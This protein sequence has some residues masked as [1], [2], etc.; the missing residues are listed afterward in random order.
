MTGA[1]LVNLVLLPL[2]LGLL[3]FIEPCS[4]GSSLLFIRY[5]GGK[6]ASAKL[7]QVIVFTLT[8]AAV[9]GSLG[10]VATVVGGAFVGL[11]RG[12]WLLLGSL[13]VGL[14]AAYLAGK[15]GVLMRPLGPSPGR[16]SG[17]RG[18][19][20]LAVLFGLNIPACAAPL[21]AAVLGSAA[22]GGAG[23]ALRAAQGFAS[24]ALFGLA[25]SLPLALA[26]LWPPMRR[27]LDRLSALSTRVRIWIGLALIAL[28]I[29]S[30]YL[31]LYP[32]VDAGR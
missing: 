18:A 7:A 2:G 19:A 25:L 10:L 5:V 11:Q 4:I 16:L 24:L 20:G 32:P 26:I 27:A 22:V 12:G 21:L 28:G 9:I 15:A 30:I 6:D 31:A 8:R 3:G 17:A 1:D 13:Y 23:G 14:G 29:W